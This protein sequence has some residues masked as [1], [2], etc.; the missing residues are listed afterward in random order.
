MRG[1]DERMILDRDSNQCFICGSE[2]DCAHREPE[3]SGWRSRQ[4]WQ[5]RADYLENTGRTEAQMYRPAI[6]PPA[7]A[8]PTLKTPASRENGPELGEP[9]EQARGRVRRLGEAYSA[10]RGW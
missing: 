7:V 9:L 6:S 5:R 10:L 3:L 8:L 1:A 2:A 4:A